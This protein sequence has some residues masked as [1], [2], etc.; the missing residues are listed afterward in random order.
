MITTHS[1][2]FLNVLRP[3]EVRVLYRDEY[4]Y[5]QAR[6]AADIRGIEEFMEAGA[7][8]GSLWM[9]GYFG[10][11]DPLTDSGAP[12]YAFD[13]PGSLLNA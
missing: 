4:G 2:Y 1:P 10:V 8:L 12:K 6:R 3:Q 11:G 9:E 5:T 13:Q 7:Q